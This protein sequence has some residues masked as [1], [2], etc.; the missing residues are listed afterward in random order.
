M[1]SPPIVMDWSAGVVTDWQQAQKNKIDRAR[2]IEGRVIERNIKWKPPEE[3]HLKINV[4]ASLSKESDSFAIGMVI[5]VS[6]GKF[7][8]GKVI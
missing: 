7:I 5:R 6:E 2:S 1:L 8:E 4:D 3:G